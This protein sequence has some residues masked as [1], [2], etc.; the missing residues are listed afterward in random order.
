MHRRELK[1][2]EIEMKKVF[3]MIAVA[4]FVLGLSTL[5]LAD[6]VTKISGNTITVVDG[7]GKAKTIE[8]NVQGLKVGDKVK[9][10]TRNGRT[11]LDPQPEP[12]APAALQEK[13]KATPE[14]PPP[15][16][17]PK[18]GAGQIK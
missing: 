7:T 9:V 8:S 15:P 11:W 10:T 6:T 14:A 17:P 3:I 13:V 1:G 12:P 4:A 18:K 5:S 16:P 2:G